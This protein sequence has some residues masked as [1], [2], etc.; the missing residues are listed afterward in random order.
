VLFKHLNFYNT[1]N[2]QKHFIKIGTSML[3]IVAGILVTKTGFADTNYE[4]FAAW[5]ENKSRISTEAKH[6]VE[7]LM[8]QAKTERLSTSRAIFIRT[9]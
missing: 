3:M 9:D 1:P 5:C 2:L 8:Q 7:M 4:S 6:T